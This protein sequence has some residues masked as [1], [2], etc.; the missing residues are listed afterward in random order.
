MVG[1]SQAKNGIEAI[2]SLLKSRLGD[3]LQAEL[4]KAWVGGS[5]KRLVLAGITFTAKK[6]H[7]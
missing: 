3:D 7:A 6:V 1:Q 5:N 4:D 2:K